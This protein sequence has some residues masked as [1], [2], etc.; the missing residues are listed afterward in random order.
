MKWIIAALTLFLCASPMD[1]SASNLGI[2]DIEIGM[3]KNQAIELISKHPGAKCYVS[4]CEEKTEIIRPVKIMYQFGRHVEKLLYIKTEFQ[5]FNHSTMLQA[6][7]DKYGKEDITEDELWENKAGTKYNNTVSSWNLPDGRLYVKRIG[8]RTGVGEIEMV[9]SDLQEEIK[10]QKQ[11][12][13]TV[14]GF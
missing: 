4:F 13:R 10:L 8:P 12:D 14:Q 5:S 7:I 9:S 2:R 6:M 11:K 1:S 3:S